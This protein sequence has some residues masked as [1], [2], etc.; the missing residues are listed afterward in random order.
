MYVERRNQTTSEVITRN[1]RVDNGHQD[2]PKDSRDFKFGV[3]RNLLDGEYKNISN[4]GGVTWLFH[5]SPLYKF[6]VFTVEGNAHV[7]ILSDTETSDIHID[8]K[9]MYGDKTGVFHIGKRQRFGVEDVD[10][11]IPVNIMA[12]RYVCAS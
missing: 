3:L 11:Y 1:L 5:K 6:D 10:I 9:K 8:V 2:Y 7:A 12:Y 4:I